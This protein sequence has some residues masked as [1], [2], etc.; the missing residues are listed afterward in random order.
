ME[1]HKIWFIDVIPHNKVVFEF[2]TSPFSQ[3]HKLVT[4]YYKT[5]EGTPQGTA[6][7]PNLYYTVGKS[8]AD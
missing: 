8:V 1:E 2:I 5:P 4:Y 6:I 7:A 3:K